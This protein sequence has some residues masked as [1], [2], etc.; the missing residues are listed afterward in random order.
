[1]IPTTDVPTGFDT[2]DERARRRAFRVFVFQHHPD[3]GGDP[4][5]FI[6]GLA[7]WR[8]DAGARLGAGPEQRFYRRRRG[9]AV[10]AGWWADRRARRRRPPRVE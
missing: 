10:P 1:M 7:A 3:H 6:S 4:D 9:L 2:A 8:R 5:V